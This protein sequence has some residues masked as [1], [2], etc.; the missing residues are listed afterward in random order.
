MAFTVCYALLGSLL[1]ALTLIPVL[2]TYVFRHGSQGWENPALGWLARVYGRVVIELAIGGRSAPSLRANGGLT[3]PCGILPRH[4]SIPQ[5]DVQRPL[6][7]VLVGGLL[8]TLILTLVALPSLYAFV[9]GWRQPQ[10][11]TAAEAS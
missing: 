9:V 4:E 6:A 5:P 1:L 8:S 2:A 11:L 7:T 3:S 10:K